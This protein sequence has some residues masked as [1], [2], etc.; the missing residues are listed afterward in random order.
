MVEVPLRIITN[1]GF[2]VQHPTPMN[3]SWFQVI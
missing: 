2:Q 3:K 1:D